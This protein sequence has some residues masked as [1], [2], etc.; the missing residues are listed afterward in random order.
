MRTQNSFKKTKSW[1][2]KCDS[3]KLKLDIVCNQSDLKKETRWKNKVL[4]EDYRR[5][6]FVKKEIE[7]F[8]S[9]GET[10]SSIKG[11]WWNQLWC[12]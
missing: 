4:W 6:M 9:K 1:K 8:P 12:K 10:R 11:S 7:W 2:G 3:K 5:V